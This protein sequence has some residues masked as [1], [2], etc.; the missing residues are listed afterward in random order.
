MPPTNKNLTYSALMSL[1]TK[2]SRIRGKSYSPVNLQPLHLLVLDPGFFLPSTQGDHELSRFCFND[3][4]MV[5]SQQIRLT[6]L[7]ALATNETQTPREHITYF[8]H[9]YCSCM[10]STVIRFL[11]YNWAIKRHIKADYVKEE[12]LF[13]Y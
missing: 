2:Q 12:V 4:F 3:R 5:V 11:K 8:E 1:V 7:L 13:N 10:L 6:F 9:I